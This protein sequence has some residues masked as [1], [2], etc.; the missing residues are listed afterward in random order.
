MSHRIHTDAGIY[1]K[2]IVTQNKNKNDIVAAA[3]D[4]PASVLVAA[5]MRDKEWAAK[6]QAD[7]D[8]LILSLQKSDAFKIEP[9]GN[10]HHPTIV[11]NVW[12][13]PRSEGGVITSSNPAFMPDEV[14]G[15][16]MSYLPQSLMEHVKFKSIPEPFY[17]WDKPAK[18]LFLYNYHILHM[19]NNTLGRVDMESAKKAD[20]LKWY[21]WGGKSGTKALD[22]L[23]TEFMNG[24]KGSSISKRLV[25]NQNFSCRYKIKM[26]A[27]ILDKQYNL[28]KGNNGI[29]RK[30][31]NTS[32]GDISQSKDYKY[33]LGQDGGNH[34]ELIIDYCYGDGSDYQPMGS[35]YNQPRFCNGYKTITTYN[36]DDDDDMGTEAV[37][38]IS[39]RSIHTY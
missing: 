16:I 18:A 1:S 13:K 19:A 9:Y 27:Y 5:L 30:A 24:D 36:N 31:L 12:D 17:K 2:Q 4:Q 38:P 11:D 21:K 32:Y 14:N 29:F 3:K 22:D 33:N 15:K 8:T 39:G 6:R 23:Y 34:K 25:W 10:S 35:I 26:A 7:I 37:V 20:V 28:G